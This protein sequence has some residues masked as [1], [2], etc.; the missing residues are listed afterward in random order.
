MIKPA[1]RRN[2]Y[3]EISNQIMALIQKGSW[4]PGEKIPGEIELS[5]RFEVSRNSVRESIKAL[6]LVGVLSSKSGRGTFVADTAMMHVLSLQSEGEI[7]SEYRL[8]ELM[9]ARAAIEPG[10]VALAV[11]KATDKDLS[12]IDE[13]VR[14]CTEA[15]ENKNYDFT[16]GFEFHRN[17]FRIANNRVLS[18]ILENISHGLI[19]TRKVIF[20]KHVNDSVLFEELKEHQKILDLMK[21][22][23]EEAAMIAM[24]KHI[25]KSLDRVLPIMK[26]NKS[27]AKIKPE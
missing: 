14:K 12:E 23:D 18:S 4:M 19:A 20:F 16:I 2:L 9:E 10:L 8:I 15:F 1:K 17:I 27:S 22:R 6:E 13:S 11:R 24:R 7:N 26:K 25:L 5:R 21:S 3:E